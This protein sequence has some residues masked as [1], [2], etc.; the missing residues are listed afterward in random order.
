MRERTGNIEK[1]KRVYRISLLLRRKTSEF[2][3]EYM[4]QEWG[5]ERRQGFNYIR[6]AKKEWADY[7]AKY[8]G[9]PFQVY[10]IA[11]LRDLTDEALKQNDLKLAFDIAK[12][13][14][15]IMGAYLPG[16]S[17]GEIRGQNT[18]FFYP[19]RAIPQSNLKIT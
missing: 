19:D 1:Q 15:K 3:I 17:R 6:L 7:Y 16:K 18:L 12:E 8:F 10:Y 2:L 4:R 9:V 14:A 13:E 11:H 5:I